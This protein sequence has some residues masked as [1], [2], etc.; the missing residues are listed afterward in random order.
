VTL[1]AYHANNLDRLTRVKAGH[2]PENVFRFD[3]SP[4]AHRHDRR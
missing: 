1:P 4:P 3:Q 2:D